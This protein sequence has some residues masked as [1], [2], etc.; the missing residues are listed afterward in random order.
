M[1]WEELSSTRINALPRETVFI[2]PRGA[3]EQHGLQ[4]PVMTDLLIAHGRNASIGGVIA[5]RASQRCP[6]TPGVDAGRKA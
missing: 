3:M 1:K 6:E 5:E 2:Q 4:L